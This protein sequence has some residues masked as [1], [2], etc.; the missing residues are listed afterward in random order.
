MNENAAFLPSFLRP[1]S[2]PKLV[3]LGRAHDGGYLVDARDIEQADVLIG[4]GIN[5]DWSFEEDFT[6]RNAVPVYGFDPTIGGTIF[7]KKV[8]KSLLRPHR[9]ALFTHSMKI[10]LGYR[11]FFKDANVHIDKYVGIPGSGSSISLREI[12]ESIVPPGHER[13]FLKIDIEG[14][15][16]RILEDIRDFSDKIVGMVIEFHDVDFHLQRIESFIERIPLQICHVHANNYGSRNKDGVPLAI[17]CTF[18]ASKSLGTPAGPLPHA[19]DMPNHAQR[20]DYRI[21]FR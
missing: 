21:T 14:S 3:R 9:P 17:E 8:L 12:F 20:E 6:S 2:V 16:Y 11:R 15:E 1:I 5:E 18:T 13:A 10:W 19:L 7:A 4:L